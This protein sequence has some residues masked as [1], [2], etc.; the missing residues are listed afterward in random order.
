LIFSINLVSQVALRSILYGA[1]VIE[2][3]WAL[4]LR[5]S[6]WCCSV[7]MVWVQISSW[8]EQKSNSKTVWFN[9]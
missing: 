4:D 3:S 1:D 2:W 8:K 6:D 7:S 5:L 9:F